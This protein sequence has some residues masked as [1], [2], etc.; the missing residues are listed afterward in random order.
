[1]RKVILI[2]G[3]LF[4]TIIFNIRV[5]SCSLF[6]ANIGNSVLGA[7]CLDWHNLNTVINFI[8]PS[9]SPNDTLYGRIEFGAYYGTGTYFY[10]YGG[11][12]D[13]GLF[14]AEASIEGANTPDF[15]ASGTIN[16]PGGL[17]MQEIVLQTCSTI[18]EAILLF[19]IYNCPELVTNHILVGD[20]F[21]NS[22]VIERSNNDTLA[23]IKKTGNY[24]IATNFLNAYLNNPKMYR[25][26][27]DPRYDFINATLKN[28]D[29]ISVGLFT[30]ILQTVGHNG[31]LIPTLYSNVYD[32][33][34]GIVYVYNYY[35]F[36]EVLILDINKELSKGNRFLGLPKLFSG[37]KAEYPVSNASVNSSSVDFK[38]VGDA[39]NYAIWLS[40]ND[41]FLNPTI[42][43]YSDSKTQ[44]AGFGIIYSIIFLVMILSVKRKKILMLTWAFC[45]V[46]LA[47]C[48]KELDLT[49]LPQTQSNI[50]HSTIID[51]LESNTNYYWKIVANN[52]NGINTETKVE[53]FTT[54]N[55][56]Q[57]LCLFFI[58]LIKLENII[59]AGT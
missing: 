29:S 13:H 43:N 59:I 39:S 4:Y 3:I 12:N 55:F 58:N 32:L 50:G 48:T 34:N 20:R 41:Q 51:N 24:Q 15:Y 31:D 46:L 53:S 44:K 57:I 45:I 5:E 11:V 35:N 56:L 52:S 30:N 42:I 10:P 7:N 25:F 22:V 21:G 49:I 16:C 36:E 27:E 33:K 14:Y 28:K 26:I 1:M 6:Y 47:G 38:W 8:P 2:T 18:D 40:T 9:Y 17:I 54:S 37:I 19:K 23:F